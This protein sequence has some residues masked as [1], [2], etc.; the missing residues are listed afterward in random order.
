MLIIKIPNNNIHERE[1]IIQLLFSEF[2]GLQYSLII[3]DT[4]LN[5]SISFEGSELCIKDGFFGYYQ[6]AS[7]YLEVAALPQKIIFAKNEFTIENNIPIIYGTDELQVFKNKIICGI[8]IFAS[9]FFL[10]TRWEEYINKV[11]DSF[12]RFPGKE[13]TAFKNSFLHRP[14]VNEYAEMLWEMMKALGFK[15]MKKV[16]NFELALT[17]D[18]DVLNYSFFRSTLVDLFKKKSLKLALKNLK[19]LFRK[20][21][22]DRFDFLMNISEALGVKSYFYFMSTNNRQKFDSRYYLNHKKFASTILEIKKR[23][24]IIG[25]HPGYYTFDN[26]EK[27]RHEK[28]LLEVAVQQEILEGRQHFLRMDVTKTLAIWDANDMKIDSTLGYSDIEGFR[29]GTGDVFTVFDFL[30]RKK[31]LLKE[32]PLI[33]MDGTLR[34]RYSKEQTIEIIKYYVSV[35]KK[36]NSIITLLFHNT[37]FI[38]EWEAYDDIYKEL[39]K[40]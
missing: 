19:F 31:L 37:S 17:H 3:S 26:P 2:L 25:F 24:H 12:V 8:D 7:S 11:R 20:D 6:D 29:C 28:Q 9:S 5:Y 21:P 15:E 1:Y 33:I 10:L 38:R 35:G 18:I 13:S 34:N 14:V 39:L 36:Y 40:M 16:R 22:Y 27:W 30:N 32:R 4:E 23:G